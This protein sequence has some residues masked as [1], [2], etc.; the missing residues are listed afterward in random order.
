MEESNYNLYLLQ[1]YSSLFCVL[2]SQ[3]RRVL[4]NS[5]IN[6]RISWQVCSDEF[7][8]FTDEI[9][10]PFG[11]SFVD[12]AAADLVTTEIETILSQVSTFNDECIITLHQSRLSDVQFLLTVPQGESIFSQ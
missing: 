6:G 3:G 9:G 2:A 12:A 10:I 4:V 1:N 5:N 7:C 8:C 11:F